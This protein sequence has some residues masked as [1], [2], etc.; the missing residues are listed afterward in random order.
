VTERTALCAPNTYR[1]EVNRPDLVAHV[2]L[3]AGISKRAAGDAVDAFLAAILRAV[4]DDE[5]VSLVGFGTFER[6]IRAPRAACNPATGQRVMVPA[7]PVPVFRPARA[8]KDAC[9]R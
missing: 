4:A 1:P 7:T 8:F 5:R 6:R 2:A 9:K 3:R